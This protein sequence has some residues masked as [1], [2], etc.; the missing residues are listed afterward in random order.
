[1]IRTLF[2]VLQN[3]PKMRVDVASCPGSPVKDKFIMEVT[4]KGYP[5]LRKTGEHNV[6]DEI[7]S[8]REGC[9]LSAILQS[10]GNECPRFN[11]LGFEEAEGFVNDFSDVSSLG[12]LVNDGFHWRFVT[13]L[14][15]L[16]ISSL[17]ILLARDSSIV[18]GRRLMYRLIQ[19]LPQILRPLL[20]LL[21]TAAVLIL[22]LALLNIIFIVLVFSMFLCFG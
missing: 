21:L 22:I 8:Y 15:I 20:N 13:V 2:G 16:C 11:P 19:C 9:D 4:S 1:M 10:F 5:S 7:Q 18:L 17:A 12:D 3:M 6:Y 14:I